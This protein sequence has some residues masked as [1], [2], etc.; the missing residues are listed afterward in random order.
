MSGSTIFGTPGADL[1][2]SD[3]VS[4]GV[5]GGPATGGNDLILGGEGN[6][7]VAGGQG[8]DTIFGEGGDDLLFGGSGADTLDGGTGID[9]V[10]YDEGEPG[11]GST[12][13]LVN[14]TT[15]VVVRGAVTLAAGTALDNLGG[16]D[17]LS[18]IENVQGS[19][20][21]DRFWGDDGANTFVG[22]GGA[23][24]FYGGGG[25]DSFIGDTDAGSSVWYAMGGA[26]G[27]TAGVIVNLSSA[28]SNGVAARTGQDGQGGTDTYG[29]GIRHAV[30]TSFADTLVGTGS[31]TQF[32]YLGGS[33]GNDL[34]IAPT[35]G[36]FTIATYTNDIAGITANLAAN[37]VTDG[38]GNTD[39]L[40]NV[41]HIRGSIH[42]DVL[43][44]GGVSGLF[45]GS[46]GND[47]ISA[48]GTARRTVDY[49][50]GSVVT[51]GAV[52]ITMSS[53]TAATV[54]KA[55]G[56][57][58]TLTNITDILGSANADSFTA[59]AQASSA[60]TI[61][62][63]PGAGNDT[64]N[65]MNNG[66]FAVEYSDA[67]K[68][69]IINLATGVVSQDGYDGTDTL[70]GVTRLRLSNFDDT[71]TGGSGND[72]FEVL[73]HLG[74][75][76][77]S[78]GSG[79][80]AYRFQG[81]GKI[82]ASI[83][84]GTV[85][86]YD[87]L[88]ALGGTDQITG[89]EYLVGGDGSDTLT[90]GTG[91][92]V[93][94]GGRGTDLINGGGGLDF[95][96][97]DDQ[98][99]N[100]PAIATGVRVNLSGADVVV[101]GVT[102][103]A[104]TAIDAW[105]TTDTVL[106]LESVG[107]TAFADILVGNAAPDGVSLTSVRGGNGADTLVAPTG[108]TRVLADYF[109]DPDANLDG[110]GVMA[111]LASGTA[112]DGWG[113]ADTLIG[114]RAVNG[115]AFRD[116]LSGSSNG[117]EYLLGQGGD[118]TLSGGDG[119]DTLA[120]GDGND[121]LSGG[122]GNDSLFGNA[123]NDLMDAGTAGT[124]LMSGGT[125]DDVY[126]IRSAPMNV[127]E[128]AGEGND[129]AFVFA[130]G[131]FS[132]G[133]IE[134]IL[135]LGTATQVYGGST[136]ETIYAN[137]S[138]A[139]TLSGNGSNDVLVGSAFADTLFG[140]DGNDTIYGQGGADSMTGGAGDDLFFVSDGGTFIAEFSGGGNDVAL[141]NADSWIV[142]PGALESVLLYGTG[143]ALTGHAGGLT[144]SIFS[145][146]GGT[147]TGLGGND[148]LYGGAFADTL[149]GGNGQDWLIGQGGDDQMLGGMGDDLYVVAQAGDLVVEVAGAGNDT[150]F[151]TA[152][153]WVAPDGLETAVLIDSATQLSGGTG[154]QT[155]VANSAFASTLAGGQGN[156][157][158]VSSG[159][160]DTLAGGAG[161]DVIT[162]GGGADVIWLD[163]PGF[164]NDLVTTVQA[165]AFALRFAGSGIT[166]L[167]QITVTDFGYLAD[168]GATVVHL[169]T[170]QGAVT[171]LGLSAQQVTDAITFA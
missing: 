112:T 11:D 37:Q 72:T 166:A 143:R 171:V 149:N 42:N 113:N 122:T 38:W 121:T 157:I 154:V 90:G 35:T 5:V 22:N 1:I 54:V 125:G 163:T 84:S 55:A 6:D 159:L 58:D 140:G 62:F 106:N 150:A 169:G 51:D 8:D 28:T 139:S 118:D 119:G 91:N 19:F 39:T 23:D 67:L 82:V 129:T 68:A 74:S 12:G 47:T 92:D 21:A 134:T 83:G 151:V 115:G 9:T 80:D 52:A 141:V 18:G 26:Q 50:S 53:M 103:A 41:T 36:T 45:I 78:G 131:W 128:A 88:G 65:G 146:A 77:L 89:I 59:V 66:R 79:S 70:T 49:R 124:D 160:G 3:G 104:S 60:F 85:A 108:A 7:S 95:L 44:A 27:A 33:A 161:D 56:G 17:V 31:T 13:V 61:R 10:S 57:T 64:V 15:G 102:L 81:A 46:Q 25:N 71:V 162:G 94:H 158:L 164:G 145:D 168:F 87:T 114:I 170:A 93:F 32:S 107:G 40:V 24:T 2:T 147:L 29:T 96:Q 75:K 135:L 63:R 123:G 100:A 105:N 126:A 43:M 110:N 30:G 111:N 86:K 48:G 144:M 117:G 152:N 167:N 34:L 155:L 116:V 130:N 156:D 20:Q 133:N 101:N 69:V 138:F 120:G 137:A 14:L 99:A 16:T 98:A 153:G 76:V 142:S 127:F 136:A 165:G 132:A 73:T 148:V 109:S 4:A 97:M